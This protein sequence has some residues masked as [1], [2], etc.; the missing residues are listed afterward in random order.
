M[1]RARARRYNVYGAKCI[2]FYNFYGIISLYDIIYLWSYQ[3][4][5]WH[6]NGSNMPM[7]T[8]VYHILY[9]IIYLLYYTPMVFY[10]YGIICE[11]Q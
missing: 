6:V 11:M 10:S 7:A 3:F 8:Y 2:W 4:M 9:S 5:A 1:K